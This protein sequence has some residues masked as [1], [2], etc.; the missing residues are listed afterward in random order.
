MTGAKKIV[1][2]ETSLSPMGRLSERIYR[3]LNRN[4]FVH[5]R[6]RWFNIFRRRTWG[7][8]YSNIRSCNTFLENVEKIPFDNTLIDGK[9][10]KDRMI[11]EVHFLRAYT[12]H[13]MVCMWGGV[14]IVDKVYGLTDDFAAPRDTYE[15]CINFI[16]AECDLA[17]SLLPD[18]Q[19]GANIGRA[20][21]G[22]ALALKSRVLLY[23][24]SDLHNTN[25]IQGYSD[26]ELLG[27]IGGDRTA[28]WTAAKNAAKEVIDLQMYSLYMANPAPGDSAAQNI[29][30]Y[31]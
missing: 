22:A 9:T 25:V 31:I 12:Y 20:T 18:V 28:R 5:I 1:S 2:Q 26:P 7:S 23:A 21:K 16:V 4:F 30:N 14:P 24:A 10:L 19:S 11:G 27:Y 17:V 29:S 6:N 15:D 3:P 13:E 8:F